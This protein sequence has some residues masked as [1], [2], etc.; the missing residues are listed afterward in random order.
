MS[1]QQKIPRCHDCNDAGFIST[2]RMFYEWRVVRDDSPNGG[3]PLLDADGKE[4]YEEVTVP[5]DYAAMCHCHA[6]GPQ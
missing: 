6:K 1:Y 3:K 2:Q 4:Q 5:R